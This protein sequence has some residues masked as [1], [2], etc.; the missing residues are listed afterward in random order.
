MSITMPAV[1]KIIGIQ[2]AGC[3]PFRKIGINIWSIYF[4][5]AITDLIGILPRFQ[6]Q[7]EERAAADRRRVGRADRG[8]Q[9]PQEEGQREGGRAQDPQEA[10]DRTGPY[11]G[12]LRAK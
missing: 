1:L 5:M 4:C 6:R 12:H 2:T 3:W 8:E 10:D 7:E 9:R 11:Q